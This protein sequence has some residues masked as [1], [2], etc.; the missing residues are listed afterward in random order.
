MLKSRV[1]PAP[2]ENMATAHPIDINQIRSRIGDLKER[3][4]SLRGYL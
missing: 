3:V 1:H 2:D 4:A